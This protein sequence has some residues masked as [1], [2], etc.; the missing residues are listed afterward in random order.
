MYDGF[1]GLFL[2]NK[3]KTAW[4]GTGG[5]GK[6]NNDQVKEGKPNGLYFPSCDPFR[7]AAVF[8]KTER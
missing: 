5:K 1:S 3:V 6:D 4:S 2:K 8:T 7:L